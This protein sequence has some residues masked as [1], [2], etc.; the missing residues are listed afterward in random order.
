GDLARH[1]QLD[2]REH[3]FKRRVSRHGGNFAELELFE[4]DVVE[5]VDVDG[6]AV[7]RGVG[8]FR[9]GTHVHRRVHEAHGVAD[10]ARVTDHQR[11]AQLMY[12]RALHRLDDN[13]R[14]DAGGVAHADADD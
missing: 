10:D 1:G 13:F 4:V 7:E 3:R 5:V 9:D 8:D 14:S 11:P 6:V 2:H 12:G